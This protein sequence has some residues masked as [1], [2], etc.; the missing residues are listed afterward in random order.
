MS[1]TY[2]DKPLMTQ[3]LTT[4]EEANEADES[5]KA[6]ANELARDAIIDD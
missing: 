3:N 5:L 2:G 4:R 1:P 6:Y